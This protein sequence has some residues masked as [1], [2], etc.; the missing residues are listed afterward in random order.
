[1]STTEPQSEQWPPGGVQGNTGGASGPRSGFWR[2][3]A[4]LIIDGIIVGVVFSVLFVLLKGVGYAIGFILDAGYFT[5][6]EG[7]PTGQTPGKR[8]MG[9]RVI[10]FDGGGPIGYGRGFIR[11]LGRIVSAIVL[12]IGYLWMLWDKESQCW[13]DK[14]ANTVVVPESSYPVA[15]WPS[16]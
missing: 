7:G 3:A 13:Q 15:N 14:F 16:G 2:R 8:V 10:D 5:Y 6:F 9:I 4:A 12:Y 11:F 1:M